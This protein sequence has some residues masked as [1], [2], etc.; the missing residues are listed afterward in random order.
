MIHYVRQNDTTK[1]DTSFPNDIS[2][3]DTCQKDT[4]Q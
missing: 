3:N 1:Y 2:Q 4:T